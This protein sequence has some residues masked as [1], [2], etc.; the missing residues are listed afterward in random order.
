MAKVSV[1]VP[2]FNRV[3]YLKK[4]IES[5]LF[6]DYE[7]YEI[8]IADNDST[9][10]TE[11]MIKGFNSERIIYQKNEQ[12]I[13]MIGNHNKTLDLVTGDYIHIFSDDDVMKQ[14]SISKKAA[15][16]DAY[17][18][19]G[20]VHSNIDIID[21]DDKV[22]STHWGASY[23]E[24]WE[25]TH[26]KSRMFKGL[27]YFKTLYY[28]WNVISMPSVMIRASVLKAAGSQFNPKVKFAMD[29]EMWMR[30]CL[31]SDVF[32]VNESLVQY[33]IHSSNNILEENKDSTY[34]EFVLIKEILF[35]K[36]GPMMNAMGIRENDIKKTV[37]KQVAKYPLSAGAKRN[38]GIRYIEEKMKHLMTSF[39]KV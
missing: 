2:T 15:I 21:G 38:Y 26:N 16:L 1:I 28:H 11:E 6:Q 5:I 31:F 19:V 25:K 13:G 29:L 24:R 32:Y 9:D 17:S 33:R 12:N 4:V 10:N 20:L 27:E 3:H 37:A 18:N 35:E 39:Y 34:N 7:D 22:L 36:F 30:I 23:Y 8:I 14:G